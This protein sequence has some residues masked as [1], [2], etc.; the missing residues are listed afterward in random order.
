[1]DPVGL[2]TKNHCVG[3]DKKKFSSQSVAVSSSS[4]SMRNQVMAS[5]ARSYLRVRAAPFLKQLVAGFPPQRPGFDPG[6]WSSGI[7]GAQSGI[8]A[9]FLWVTRFPLPIFIP[10]IAP[11]SPSPTIWGWHNRPEVAAVQG[12]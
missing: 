7:C 8:G 11:Q 6:V 1:M 4:Q 9:G 5:N 2:R 12:T 10:P 3:K